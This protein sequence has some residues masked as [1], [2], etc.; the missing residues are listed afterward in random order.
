LNLCRPALSFP[1]EKTKLPYEKQKLP[2]EKTKLPSEEKKPRALNLPKISAGYK[3]ERVSTK[4][5]QGITGLSFPLWENKT[6]VRKTAE[7]MRRN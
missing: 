1:S 4:R 6:T 2:Y 3:S 7:L 5:F